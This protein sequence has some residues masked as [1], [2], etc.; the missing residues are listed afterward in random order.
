[1]FGILI[2]NQNETK[3]LISVFYDKQKNKNWKNSLINKSENGSKLRSKLA[4][5]F[6]L[7]IFL[8]RVKS[9][10]KNQQFWLDQTSQIDF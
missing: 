7:I 6:K 3:I 9:T 8:K 4:C 1:V 5:W 10:L 2:K